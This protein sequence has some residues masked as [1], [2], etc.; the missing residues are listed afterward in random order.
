MGTVGFDLDRATGK[1]SNFGRDCEE[2][3]LSFTT[4]TQNSGSGTLVCQ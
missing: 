2:D 4:S 1:I 3:W